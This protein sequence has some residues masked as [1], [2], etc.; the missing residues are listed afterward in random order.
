MSDRSLHVLS[1]G[2]SIS[3]AKHRA[4]KLMDFVQCPNC[5]SVVEIPQEAV[6]PM[7]TDPW[8]V[9]GCDECGV[10][11]DY[12]DDEVQHSPESSNPW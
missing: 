9:I 7:R 12:D 1:C 2:D 5:G 8:N 3:G 11:F 10:V 6:G 4:S